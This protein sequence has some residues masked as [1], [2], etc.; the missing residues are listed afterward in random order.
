MYIYTYD[1]RFRGS[2]RA[3]TVQEPPPPPHTHTYIYIFIYIYTRCVV[4]TE[5]SKAADE[6]KLP[7]SPITVFFTADCTR[8][9]AVAMNCVS[10]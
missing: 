6:R 8:G 3:D 1:G 4:T 5:E 7:R 2:R 10:M 9:G